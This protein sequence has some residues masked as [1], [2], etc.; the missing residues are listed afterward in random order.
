ME[1]KHQKPYLSEPLLLPTSPSSPPDISTATITSNSDI[2]FRFAC[3]ILIGTISVWAN[4]EAS[5][6]FSIT[7][8]NDA[9]DSFAAKRF[10]HFYI[11]DDKATR[12]ILE[13][14]KFVENLL[15]PRDYVHYHHQSRFFKKHVNHVTLRLANQNMSTD[16]TVESRANNEYVLH[17]DP[18][19]MQHKNFSHA[20]V[21]AIRRGMARIWLWD[22]HGTVPQ[23]LT[24]GMIEYL[25]SSFQ[26]ELSSKNSS[27]TDRVAEMLVN[28]ENQNSGFVRQLNQAM[29]DHWHDSTVDYLSGDL[30]SHASLCN[31]II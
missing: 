5:K 16:I 15:Y 8:I 13:T 18:S 2:L 4:Y 6:G 10:S 9:A 25:S 30:K 29:R 23:P 28:C 3:I 27:E 31:Y 17:L 14:S 22:G 21:S 7:V 19:I 24:N 12:I 26:Q 1:T 20:I 11:S